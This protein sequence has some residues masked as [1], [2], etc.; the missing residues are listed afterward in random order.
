MTRCWPGTPAKKAGPTDYEVSRQEGAESTGPGQGSGT[1]GTDQHLA[2]GMW[3]RCCPWTGAGEGGAP[4]PPKEQ[5]EA[6]D[7]HPCPQ[8]RM[9]Q[10]RCILGRCLDNRL[11][12]GGLGA[13]FPRCWATTNPTSVTPPALG[14]AV[15]R[16][17]PS[18]SSQSGI[19]SGRAPST[20]SVTLSP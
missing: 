13:R 19:R 16:T 5:S 3:Q 20:G 14:T 10:A 7:R 11:V 9:R 18:K 1:S 17:A 2:E 15:Q 6:H 12:T 8:Q 4:Q